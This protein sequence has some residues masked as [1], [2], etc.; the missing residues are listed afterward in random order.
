MRDSDFMSNVVY[1]FESTFEG[2][3]FS[4]LLGLQERDLNIW[5][6]EYILFITSRCS[7]LT[8]QRE[9]IKI[10]DIIVK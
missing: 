7:C 9:E 2:L 8:A 10:G 5:I 4:G 1:I 6:F 3:Y